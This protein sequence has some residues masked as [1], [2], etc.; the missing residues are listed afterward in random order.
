ML[1]FID[2]AASPV[3]WLH[4]H[5]DL[6]WEYRFRTLLQI[7]MKLGYWR[8]QSGSQSLDQAKKKRGRGGRVIIWTL[9]FCIF[10]S[11]GKNI[12]KIFLCPTPQWPLTLWGD[13]P[14]CGATLAND[15][16]IQQNDTSFDEVSGISLMAV[17]NNEISIK[18]NI[19][20]CGLFWDK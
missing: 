1:W 12:F 7:P 9:L 16:W 8:K 17:L 10:F 18:N 20:V 5:K 19:C 3:S 11:F 2:T 14:P 13:V 15:S 4:T 6:T